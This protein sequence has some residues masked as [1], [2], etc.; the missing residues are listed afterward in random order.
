[1]CQPKA[2]IL[3]NFFVDNTDNDEETLQLIKEVSNKSDV[4]S[5]FQNC[6]QDPRFNSQCPETLTSV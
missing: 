2:D 5:S 1:M 6:L 4:L 3:T